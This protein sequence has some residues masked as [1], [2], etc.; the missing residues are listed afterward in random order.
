MKLKGFLSEDH[1]RFMYSIAGWGTAN[2]DIAA[3][4]SRLS[5]G[6]SGEH[7]RPDGLQIQMPFILHL[8][9]L[10]T[11]HTSGLYYKVAMP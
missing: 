2:C 8:T 4:R 3:M 9:R 11:V 5:I 6:D 7:D 10:T 1:V